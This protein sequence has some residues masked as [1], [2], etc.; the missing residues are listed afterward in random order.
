MQKVDKVIRSRRRTL[1][2]EINES[3]EVIVRAPLK[4]PEQIIERFVYDKRLW[5]DQKTSILKAKQRDQVKYEKGE[6]FLYLGVNYE[7]DITEK[8]KNFFFDDKFFLPIKKKDSA[9]KL[10]ITWYKQQAAIVIPERVLYFS[11]IMGLSYN[12]VKLTSAKKRWGSCSGRNNLNFTWRLIMSPLDIIDYVIVHELAHV[13]Q[14]NHSKKFWGIVEK[15]IPD[16]K[17]R[18]KWLREFGF[19]LKL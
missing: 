4:M 9:E 14:K 19:K 10:F 2:L 17:E 5:I 8:F 13:V 18:R 7:L 15:Y 6:L 3:A 12:T 11:K 1:S 16:Y